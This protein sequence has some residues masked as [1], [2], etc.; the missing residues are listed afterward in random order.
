MTKLWKMSWTKF[1][2]F[3]HDA[4]LFWYYVVLTDLERSTVSYVFPLGSSLFIGLLFI[5]L[6]LSGALQTFQWAKAF[7]LSLF[8]LV[9]AIFKS[10]IYIIVWVRMWYIKKCKIITCYSINWININ[11]LWALPYSVNAIFENCFDICF[12]EDV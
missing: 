7:Y 6:Q 11:W 4:H 10:Y 3:M 12:C 9:P 8:K 2:R 5:L 1:C